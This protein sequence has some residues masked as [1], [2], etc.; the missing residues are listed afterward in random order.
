MRREKAITLLRQHE[1]EIRQAGVG[2]LFLF[3][4]VARNEASETSDV[5]LFFDLERVQGF[6]LFDLID[7]QE[8]MQMI[9]GTRVDLMTR[10]GIHP[11][12]RARIEASA[13]QVF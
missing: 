7:L 5:D 12:R 3:G 10:K 8:H 6:T 11:R 1:P 4:S 13:V 9:L 2:A